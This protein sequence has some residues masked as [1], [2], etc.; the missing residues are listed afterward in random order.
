MS[1]L[2]VGGNPIKIYTGTTTYT[3]LRK[4][5]L[6]HSYE[7]ACNVVDDNYDKCKGLIEVFDTETGDPVE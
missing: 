5:A 2:V 1:Y 6:V 4:I 7:E 3:S